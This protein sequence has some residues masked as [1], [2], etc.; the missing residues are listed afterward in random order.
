[1]VEEAFRAE[2]RIVFRCSVCNECKGITFG[3]R[4][5]I[6][7]NFYFLHVTL[8]KHTCLKQFL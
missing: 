3:I 2:Y 4:R 8:H 5:L 1:M 7:L 6:S